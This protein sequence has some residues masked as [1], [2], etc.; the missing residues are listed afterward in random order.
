MELWKTLLNDKVETLKD[1]CRN[2]NIKGYSKLRKIELIDLICNYLLDENNARRIFMLADN[3]E[4][5]FFKKIINKKIKIIDFADID[6]YKYLS[7]HCYILFKTVNGKNYCE[8]VN[9]V[10]ELFNNI[11]TDEFIKNHDH[12]HLVL[13][14]AVALVNLYGIVSLEKIIEIF[15][16]QNA[17]KIDEDFLYY[18]LYFTKARTSSFIMTDALLIE[19]NL[20]DDFDDCVALND[21]QNDKPYYVPEKDLLLKYID[22]LYYERNEE[23]EKLKWQIMK[24][25]RLSDEEAECLCD[26]IM[27]DCM[28]DEDMDEILS[29]FAFHDIEISNIKQL[30]GITE[31]II[32]LMNNTRIWANRGYTP[33]EMSAI[34]SSNP[35]AAVKLDIT[36]KKAGP[37]DLCPCGSGRK[38]KKCC[39]IIR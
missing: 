37:N 9:D 36:K 18:V 11:Y 19:N 29:N 13:D 5:E 31:P 38:Y 2:I 6:Y 1:I 10:A 17:E 3:D 35:Y 34:N 32:E 8:V 21:N 12:L 20:C 24:I 16:N 30:K 27:L 22:C 33:K 7:L 4:L 26:D 25:F 28:N 23:F 14:Y 39:G 15:N